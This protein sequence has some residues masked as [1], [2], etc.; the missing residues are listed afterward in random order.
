MRFFYI[1]IIGTQEIYYKLVCIEIYNIWST[2]QKNSV[3]IQNWNKWLYFTRNTKTLY[4]QEMNSIMVNNECG[5]QSVLE[6][7]P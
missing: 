5:A 6:P 2:L 1:N 7:L 4:L 3:R